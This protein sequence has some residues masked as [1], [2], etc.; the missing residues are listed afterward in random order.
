M[1]RDELERRWDR[2]GI[3]IFAIAMCFCAQMLLVVLFGLLALPMGDRYGS[4]GLVAS[5]WRWLSML[6]ALYYVWTVARTLPL[7]RLGGR[8]TRWSAGGSMR[9]PPMGRGMLLFFGTLLTLS[10]F[11][12]SATILPKG[13]TVTPASDSVLV[14]MAGS[15]VLILRIVLGTLRLVPRSWRVVPDAVILP[16]Q[17]LAPPQGSRR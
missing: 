17:N 16:V 14:M 7:P 5:A 2:I 1:T 10:V 12:H 3:S 6:P 11:A 15:A 13:A 8:A 9:V 4:Y